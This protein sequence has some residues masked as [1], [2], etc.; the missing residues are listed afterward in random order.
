MPSATLSVRTR[1]D[2]DTQ[3]SINNLPEILQTPSGLALLE[4]QGT[5]HFSATTP[6]GTPTDIGR[7][8]FEKDETV[9][10]LYIGNHQR[11]E[12][13]IV[14]LKPP[15]GLMRRSEGDDEHEHGNPDGQSV[16]IVEVIKK[17]VVFSTRPEPLVQGV[18]FTR[19]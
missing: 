3:I 9:V 12:G 14:D 15:V 7:L 10:W 13:K 16:E 1:R 18:T 17:K 11:M 8:V 2:S 6:S 4:I 5:I 19:S